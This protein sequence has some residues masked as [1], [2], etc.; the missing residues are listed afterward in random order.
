MPRAIA[1]GR[2]LTDMAA[3][4]PIPAG[5]PS[6]VLAHRPDV[7]S[8]E[9]KLRAATARIGVAQGARLPTI[10]ITGQY[11]SQ[12]TASSRWFASGT[13][14]WQGFVGVSVPL[15]FEGRLGGEQVTIADAQAAQARARY[16]QT[17]LGALREVEDALVALRTSRDQGAAQQ[18]QT[19][20]LR[21][22]L[23]L[24]D[25]RYQTGVASYLEVLDAQ[26]GLFGAELA[27]TEA[28]R[29]QLVA[30]VALYEALGAG[31]PAAQGRG[32]G[33]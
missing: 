20:A 12:T 17:V 3:R 7:R 2:S 24:A 9:A 25:L 30:A 11:G 32:S 4:I 1:R 23:E 22:A 14:I 31:W 10:T 18:R 19:I 16:E 13:D 8:A 26:R 6:T 27:L 28:E 29:D 33:S 15:F 5:V 21:R